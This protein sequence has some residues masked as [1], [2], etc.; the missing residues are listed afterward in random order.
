MAAAWSGA[1]LSLAG[2]RYVPPA[3]PFFGATARLGGISRFS[4][5]VLQDAFAFQLASEARQTVWNAACG[6]E[7]L[8]SGSR[9]RRLGEDRVLVRRADLF[10]GEFSRRRRRWF[11]ASS[12]SPLPCRG[13]SLGSLS[14]A[15]HRRLGWSLI[16][17]HRLCRW[18]PASLGPRLALRL[19]ISMEDDVVSVASRGPRS[20]SRGFF[21]GA[22][23]I[24]VIAQA[25]ARY[26]RPARWSASRTGHISSSSVESCLRRCL[27]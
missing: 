14:R 19:I 22:F 5:R 16:W 3:V 24:F 25:P 13:F 6:F 26:H 9:L 2:K 17:H 27:V 23:L 11:G 8:A 21:G 1:E 20:G 12:S 18:A 7:V 4:R 15:A 10:S